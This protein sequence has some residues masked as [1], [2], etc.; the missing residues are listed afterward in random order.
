MK[1]WRPRRPARTAASISIPGLSRGDWR[2]SPGLLVATTAAGD[3]GFLNLVQSAFDL[4][5][6][7]VNGREA[8]GALDAFLFTERGVY[9]SGE[10][11]YV[12]AL[13][14]DAKGD[15][16]TGLPLTLVAIRPDG[17]EYKR[18]TIADQGLGGRSFA[19]PLLAGAQAGSW[20]IVA[21]VDP[22]G[23]SV[24]ETGFM[25]EDYIPERLDV[26]MKPAADILT[27]G[28]PVADRRSTRNSSMARPP[29]GST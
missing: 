25:L 10:T 18:T 3:Y 17:V 1:S 16:K 13:L 19:L 4:T 20:R 9:R 22:K 8:P 11:V 15:A 6:R 14:R 29:R 5:D 12:T 2:L 28:E 24:G 21:Y 27:P 7:G 26:K 23:A